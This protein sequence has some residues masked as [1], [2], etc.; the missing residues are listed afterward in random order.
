M[1]KKKVFYI[2]F[3]RKPSE[4]LQLPAIS[5]QVGGEIQ[6]SCSS[7]KNFVMAFF[8]EISDIRH[9]KKT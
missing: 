1:A 5:Y 9:T 3:F 4:Q 6:H 8:L 7:V 2:S